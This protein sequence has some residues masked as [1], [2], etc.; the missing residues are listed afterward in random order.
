MLEQKHHVA[1]QMGYHG[2]SLSSA[3]GYPAMPASQAMPSCGAPVM[4]DDFDVDV[5]RN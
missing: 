5:D 4:Q 1:S 3:G 2:G